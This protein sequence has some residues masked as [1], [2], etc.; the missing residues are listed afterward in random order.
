MTTR[1]YIRDDRYTVNSD[2]GSDVNV[3]LYY[4]KIQSGANQI[5]PGADEHPY[6]CQILSQAN[7]TIQWRS[8][9]SDPYHSG[10][11]LACF[12][13]MSG[14]SFP[15]FDGNDQIRLLNSLEQAVK[16]HSFNAAIA[17]GESGKS[18]KLVGDRAGQ[19]G[20]MLRY[21]STGNVNGLRKEMTL[22]SGSAGQVAR[23]AA[24]KGNSKKH[25][26]GA[27]LELQ[28]GWLPLVNDIHEASNYIYSKLNKPVSRSY[29]SGIQ[30]TNYEN[31]AQS[32]GGVYSVTQV[33]RQIRITLAEDYSPWSELGLDDPASLAW[34]LLPYSFVIDWALPIGNFLQARNFCNNVKVRSAYQSDFSKSVRLRNSYPYAGWSIIG[35]TQ[36]ST[37]VQL[38][39]GP[40]TLTAPRPNF[41]SLDKIGSF[42]HAVNGLSL[43]YNALRR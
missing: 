33:K 1:S 10:S 26:N 13:G 11:W 19:L 28:Y 21:A 2:C 40:I 30:K 8:N 5:G 34:E 35:P 3:G 42:K 17:L 9:P 39:R 25:M 24:S 14:V 4:S 32:N 43:L 37:Y 7:G 29:R 31:P 18:L 6:S 27:W 16:N 38:S 20:R 12:G 15:T 22:K 41:K 36:S 23:A